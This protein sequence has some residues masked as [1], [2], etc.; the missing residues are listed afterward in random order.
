MKIGHIRIYPNPESGFDV[1]LRVRGGIL[2]HGTFA[3]IGAALAASWALD[4]RK[5]G[6]PVYVYERDFAGSLA[7]ALAP[8][9]GA[10]AE[11]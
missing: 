7:S 11:A 8:A 9:F 5:P 10:K 2:K 1:I 3:D 4:G 6:D